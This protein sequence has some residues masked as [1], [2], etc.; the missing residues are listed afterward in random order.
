VKKPPVIAKVTRKT[1]GETVR[2]LR[3]AKGFSQRDLATKAM[4]GFT[5]ISKIETGKLDFGDYPSERLIVEIARS[6]DADPD[7]LLILARKVPDVVRR[8]ILQRPDAFLR[9]ARLDD[10]TLN[11]LLKILDERAKR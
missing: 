1:F 3:K 5:Y 11:R 2:G 7:E 9:L 6:L 10:E 8:R 4:V